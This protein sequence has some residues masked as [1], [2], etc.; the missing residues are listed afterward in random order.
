MSVLCHDAS[1]LEC[2]KVVARAS[3]LSLEGG[4]KWS[5]FVQL[6]EGNS[7]KRH[8]RIKLKLKLVFLK[9]STHKFRHS[10]RLS[11]SVG[12]I[13]HASTPLATNQDSSGGRCNA[14]LKSGG[15]G[16]LFDLANQL[17]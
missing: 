15:W 12:R 7:G 5:I 11:S 9:A 16:D 17:R 1:R 10:L 8:W 13:L 3:H 6:Y 14:T 2:C 4:G